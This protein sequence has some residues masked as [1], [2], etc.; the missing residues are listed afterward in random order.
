[1]GPDWSKLPA[2]LDSLWRRR[3]EA[4]E[5]ERIS[6]STL[7]LLEEIRDHLDDQN[8]VNHAIARIDGLRARMND[9]GTT[10][11]LVAQLNQRAQLD[12]FTADRR[13]TAAKVNPQE[14]QRR[15]V[16]RDIDNVRGMMEAAG[17][18]Q[19]LMDEVIGQL[20]TTSA[21]VP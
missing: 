20:A 6:R 3:T 4:Q 16:L 2:C 21:A 14:K 7:P 10:Y 18:F 17:R 11:E 19:E 5:I 9:V 13:I 1:P 8:R 12:R 15:Q